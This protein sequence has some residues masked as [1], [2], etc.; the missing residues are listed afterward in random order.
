MRALVV[1]NPKAGKKSLSADELMAEL[2]SVGISPSYCSSNDKAFPDCLGEPV[3]LMIAAGGDGTVAK[4]KRLVEVFGEQI[5]QAQ[6]QNV[7]IRIARIE[8]K[9][10]PC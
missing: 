8:L 1:H 3:D 9:R 5:Y 6:W 2:R 4:L 7:P 10:P